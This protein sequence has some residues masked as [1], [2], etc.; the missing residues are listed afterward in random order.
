VPISGVSAGETM[1]GIDLRPGTGQLFGLGSTSR[2]YIIDPVTGAAT[3][4]GPAGAF[5]LSGT[6]FGFDFAPILGEHDVRVVSDAD[7]NLFLNPD[8]TLRATGTNLA[9]AS[10]DPNAGANPNVVG[11]ARDNNVP[12][13]MTGT[14]YGIDSNLRTLVRVRPPV[15]GLVDTVGP[16]GL[17]FI[18]TDQTG[19][20]ISGVTGT[21]Y[22]VFNSPSSPT[23]SQLSIVNLTTGDSGGVGG[24]GAG[25]LVID[26]AAPVIIPEPAGGLLLLAA[27]PFIARRRRS[28]K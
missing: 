4:V 24:I 8:G 15:V 2:L 3:A 9:Y 26:I 28:T 11:L 5:T 17:G 16:L 27:P 12:D 23:L 22:A 14:T 19:F 10:F 6:S 20:D 18:L 7:Q 21:A 13:A 1:L 25:A